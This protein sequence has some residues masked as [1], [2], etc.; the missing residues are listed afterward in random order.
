[1]KKIFCV[2]GAYICET[3]EL[4]ERNKLV[5]KKCGVKID[6]E[7]PIYDPDPEDEFAEEWNWAIENTDE[8]NHQISGS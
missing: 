5:C 4:I 1:M 2:C 3:K 8:D 7:Q 6:V